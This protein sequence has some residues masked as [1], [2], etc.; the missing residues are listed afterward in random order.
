MIS[1]LQFPGFK[2]TS[3]PQEMFPLSFSRASKLFLLAA[4]VSSSV[5][6]SPV[7]G[8]GPSAVP[9]ENVEV[10]RDLVPRAVTALSI[11]DISS[12]SP[13]TQFAR[14]G[15]CDPAK[16][17]TWTCG[18]E[19]SLVFDPALGFDEQNFCRCLQR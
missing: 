4:A 10:E 14:A 15:Y 1:G 18:G 16:V 6:A 13:F 2:L 7:P 8:P 3:S 11:A 19:Y 12:Y 17:R 5:W 9:T